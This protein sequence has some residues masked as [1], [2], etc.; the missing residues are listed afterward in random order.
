VASGEDLFRVSLPPSHQGPAAVDHVGSLGIG[1]IRALAARGEQL[2]VCASHGY[3]VRSESATGVLWTR[4]RV[5]G[6]GCS[7]LAS[8]ATVSWAIL[9][10]ALHA[11]RA[12][13]YA[14]VLDP[15]GAAIQEVDALAVDPAGAVVMLRGGRLERYTL[16]EDARLIGIPAGALVDRPA[17]LRVHTSHPEA[18]V[19]ITATLAGQPLMVL[20]STAAQAELAIDPSALPPGPAILTVTIA[21]QSSERI[22]R[23]LRLVLGHALAEVS[24]SA[25]IWPWAV[26]AAAQ[27]TCS[28][29][30]NN[31]TRPTG[32]PK[33]ADSA[34]GW[35]QLSGRILDRAVLQAGAP[36]PPAGNPS[37]TSD[38]IDALRRWIEGAQA[39]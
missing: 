15:S 11:Q 35:R 39:P 16:D 2:L 4:H 6:T 30:S 24:W 7:G 14:P 29:H 13:D 22:Q 27:G 5:D 26:G 34:D 8:S 1:A 17:R 21:Y 36:M 19:Q 28:C 10:G 3:A 37:A 25:D 38:E 23:T 9:D 18:I 32:A 12:G 20:S 33:F 31:D